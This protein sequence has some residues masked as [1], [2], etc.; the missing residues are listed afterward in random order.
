MTQGLCADDR[1]MFRLMLID[2]HR[3]RLLDM[4]RCPFSEKTANDPCVT[5]C[6][7]LFCWTH[8]REVR[9]SRAVTVWMLIC[10]VNFQHLTASSA[11]SATCPTCGAP[12]RMDRDVVQVFGRPKVVPAD[13]PWTSGASSG[14]STCSFGP[15]SGGNIDSTMQWHPV[16]LPGP[17]N[18]D[19][20]APYLVAQNQIYIPVLSTPHSREMSL[21]KYGTPSTLGLH[22]D[23]GN[24]T[25]SASPEVAFLPPPPSSPILGRFDLPPSPLHHS[26]VN[27]NHPSGRTSFPLQPEYEHERRASTLSWVT[28]SGTSGP[29]SQSSSSLWDGESSYGSRSRSTTI[30]LRDEDEDDQLSPGPAP[31]TPRRV[32]LTSRPMKGFWATKTPM[33]WLPPK[34]PVPEKEPP[35]PIP[36]IKIR[37]ATYEE[38]PRRS[39]R[40]RTKGWHPGSSMFTF[41]PAEPPSQVG[42]ASS[43]DSDEYLSSFRP[44][45]YDYSGGDPS[46]SRRGDLRQRSRTPSRKVFRNMDV[47]FVDEDPGAAGAGAGADTG[48]D[49]AREAALR[50]VD[51]EQNPLG[52][53]MMLLALALFLMVLLK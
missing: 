26:P 36:H 5:R 1:C 17:I 48:A 50:A 2:A 49:A 43:S 21:S 37:A 20:E 40:L 7:H 13:A 11:S 42:V 41:A 39:S 29:G 31:S 45:R 25:I 44:Q 32:S 15:M 12:T 51:E 46:L 8:L 27:A 33:K 23:I 4:P 19:D 14:A 9:C 6:G 30:D 10:I 18:V 38:T 22:I 35:A 3:P 24:P 53:A 47:D 34:S 28:A 16:E 52:R